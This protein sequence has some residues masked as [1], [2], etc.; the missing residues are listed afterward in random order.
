MSSELLTHQFFAPLI[1]GFFSIAMDEGAIDLRLVEVTPLPP[2]RRRNDA[3][4]AISVMGITARAEPFSLLFTG[5][6][7]RLL[8]QCIYHMAHPSV[9]EPLDIFIVPVG[10]QPDG[11]VY[12][13]IFG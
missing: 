4:A 11:F 7:D 9:P 5:P 3:G 6:S 12:Q 2:V 1:G 13:A 8:P 10:N